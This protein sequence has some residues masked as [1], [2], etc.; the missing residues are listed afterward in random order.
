MSIAS[1]HISNNTPKPTI[2]P[3]NS[4]FVIKRGGRNCKER[5]VFLFETSIV[6]AKI[7]KPVTRGAVRYIYKY[8]LMTAEIFDVKEHLEAG[9]PCKFALYTGRP[10]SSHA[11]DLRVTLKAND[12]NTKQQWVIRIRELIQ[13]NDLYHDLTM[14]ET[15]T[16]QPTPSSSA[17]IQNKISNLSNIN[18]SDRR[19]QEIADNA[20]DEY[21]HIS[22]GGSLSSMTTG[23]FSSTGQHHQIQQVRKKELI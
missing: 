7:V 12:L 8:K 2:K 6:I 16:K 13:E 15:N 3:I 20:S 18:P 19:S 11:A 1:I 21:E 14:H 23:S 9:E 22:R 10:M 4:P 5:H 17:A